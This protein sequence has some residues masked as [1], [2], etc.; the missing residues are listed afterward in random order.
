MFQTRSTPIREFQCMGTGK[1]PVPILISMSRPL[2]TPEKRLGYH[3]AVWWLVIT[4]YEKNMGKYGKIVLKH[5]VLPVPVHRNWGIFR[6][7]LLFILLITF[8]NALI[9]QDKCVHNVHMSLSCNVST[10]FECIYWEYQFLYLLGKDPITTATDESNHVE[11]G[12]QTFWFVCFFRLVFLFQ[13]RD[14]CT[15]LLRSRRTVSRGT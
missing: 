15:E 5:G 10:S 14:V 6:S 4:K 11:L 8:V 2:F 7:L 3:W 12:T 9:L 1:L 13:G